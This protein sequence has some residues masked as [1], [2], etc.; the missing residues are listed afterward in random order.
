[1]EVFTLEPSQRRMLLEMLVG[2]RTGEPTLQLGPVFGR[3]ATAEQLCR[4]RLAVW[5]SSDHITFTV[6]GR[7]LA[8]VLADRLGG[9]VAASA[10]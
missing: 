10:C 2:E 6:V 5:V 4:L 8:E 3:A 9:P 1:M 7:D